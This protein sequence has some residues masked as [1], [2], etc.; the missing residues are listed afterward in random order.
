MR[1]DLTTAG[2]AALFQALASG[3]PS[4]DGKLPLD[5]A[6]GQGYLQSVGL[7]PRLRVLLFQLEL[8]R[9]LVLVRRADPAR[10]VLTFSFRNLL[11]PAGRPAGLATVQVMSAGMDLEVTLPAHTPV[12]TLLLIADPALF[13][14]LRAGEAVPALLQP[15]LAGHQPFVYEERMSPAM[16]QVAAAFVAADVP[17]EVRPYYQRVKAEELLCLFLA[18]LVKRG[19]HA[20]H[21]PLSSLDARQL[22]HVRDQLLQDLGQPPRLSA[23]AQSA[24]WSESKLKRLF[25]QVFGTPVYQYHQA[26]RLQEAVRLL[27]TQQG[28]VSEVGYR[29]G[30]QNLSHFTQLF[31]RHTGSRPKQFSKRHPRPNEKETHQNAA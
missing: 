28:S 20:G 3:P 7:G 31:T 5:H 8:R 19:P 29:L 12:N 23:L 16:Q 26:A 1:I 24:A 18:E 30:F 10:D 13:S 4:E 27:S 17:A 15:L 25:K 22:Y 9:E 21:S 14:D 11:A 2:P 6:V